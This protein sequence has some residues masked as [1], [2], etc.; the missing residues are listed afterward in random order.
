MQIKNNPCNS[1]KLKSL[2]NEQLNFINGG[3]SES[4]GGGPWTEVPSTDPAKKNK[5]IVP[6]LE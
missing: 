5:K 2:K 4:E 6:K 3:S 1:S